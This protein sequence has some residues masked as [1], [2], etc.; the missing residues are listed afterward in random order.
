MIRSSSVVAVA[1]VLILAACSSGD[2]AAGST[3]TVDSAGGEVFAVMFDGVECVVEGPTEVS[4]GTYPFVMTDVSGMGGVDLRT[5]LIDEEHDYDDLVALQGES[6][7]YV[8]MPDWGEF[9]LNAFESYDGELQEN[10]E[11]KSIVLESGS[12][13]IVIGTGK[14]SGTWICAEL[15]VAAP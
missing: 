13:A 9:S 4:P 12:H 3:T 5:M 7:E 11:S 10:E 6:G 14:P 1:C 8:S 15:E 2:D